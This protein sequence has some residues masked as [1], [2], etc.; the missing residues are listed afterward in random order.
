LFPTWEM[1]FHPNGKKKN[2]FFASN[3]KPHNMIFS[4]TPLLVLL[5]AA[6]VPFG[7]CQDPAQGNKD[8]FCFDILL[9]AKKKIKVGSDMLKPPI[10]L[11]LSPTLKPNGKFLLIL[12]SLEHFFRHGRADFCLLIFFF[13]LA[14][15]RVTISTLFN[16]S[17]LGLVCLAALVCFS[18]SHLC[19]G[20][21]WQIYN[22]YFQWE[23]EY[24]YNSPA[25][26]VKA[27]D[28]LFGS[29]TYDPANQAY[30]VFHSDMT[31]GWNITSVIPI[32]KKGDGNYKDYTIAYFVM[33]KS[34]NCNQYPPDGIVTFYDI[35]I[36]YNKQTVI[37]KWT[38]G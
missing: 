14:S 15:K 35:K 12:W 26:H 22:E 4:S 37:P 28:V 21:G 1:L 31:D 20:Q 11:E 7:Y 6:A 29:V 3:Q 34:W 18:P 17:T 19:T 38:T 2:V 23:P 33:E 25:H 27:G 9:I 36:Q 16:L 24:N 30:V 32:Q 10:Q 5:L 8:F 13:G